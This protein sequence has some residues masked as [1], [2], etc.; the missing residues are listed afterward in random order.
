MK[1]ISNLLVTIT[2]LS[3]LILGFLFSYQQW[4]IIRES[5][6]NLFNPLSQL[7]A[8]FNVLKVP[9]FWIFGSIFAVSCFMLIKL[10]T[11]LE[12][13]E[14]TKRRL[15]MYEKKFLELPEEERYFRVD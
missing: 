7:T 3:G 1:T 4:L 8:C 6:V 10:N 14:E 5:F 12:K 11:H 15:A 9:A 13:D 2:T